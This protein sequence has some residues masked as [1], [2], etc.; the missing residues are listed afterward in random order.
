MVFW[1]G[2]EVFE[3]RLLPVTFHMIPIINHTVSDRVVYTITRCP[4][5]SQG[6]ISNEE[7]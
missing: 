2:P 4:R 6:F 5:I 7:I 3:D 1:F